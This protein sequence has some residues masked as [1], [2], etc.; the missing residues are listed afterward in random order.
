MCG[1][2]ALCKKFTGVKP[3]L[4][5]SIEKNRATRTDWLMAALDA[6]H[7]NPRPG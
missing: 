4:E 6:L 7:N 2:Q 1:R 3:S 5:I